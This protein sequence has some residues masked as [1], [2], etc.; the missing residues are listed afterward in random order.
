MHN[1]SIHS[2]ILTMFCTNCGGKR[3]EGAKF[4][5]SCGTAA[6]AV[7]E[8]PVVYTPPSTELVVNIGNKRLRNG[9]T[10]FWLWLSFILCSLALLILLADFFVLHNEMIVQMIPHSSNLEEW[11]FRIVCILLFWGYKQLLFDWSKSGFWMV[12]IASAV[13]IFLY[14]LDNLLGVFIAQVAAVGI[15]FGVLQFKNAYNAK[16]TWE[17]LSRQYRF[18]LRS[19][20]YG[21]GHSAFIKIKWM[22]CRTFI[23][24]NGRHIGQSSPLC[25][26]LFASIKSQPTNNPLAIFFSFCWQRQSFV[27][28]FSHHH[29]FSHPH[30]PGVFLHP[31]PGLLWP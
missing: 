13:F 6:N 21:A 16:S 1:I 9:F 3:N 28:F 2:S 22:I 19:I 7:R 12:V 20:R 17:Q 8:T 11:I 29:L 5:P 24:K 27:H 31:R 25:S 18:I 4:C 15:L 23:N 26:L 14:P 30:P 10:S